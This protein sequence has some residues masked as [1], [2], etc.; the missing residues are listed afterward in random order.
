MID[1]HPSIDSADDCSPVY[2]HL[3][4]YCVSSSRCCQI[5]YVVILCLS[6]C[7]LF[8]MKNNS[9]LYILH[10]IIVY[11]QVYVLAAEKLCS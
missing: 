3:V 5:H 7:K 10:Y 4:S 6:Y 2:T 8:Y 9:V 1:H 11:L